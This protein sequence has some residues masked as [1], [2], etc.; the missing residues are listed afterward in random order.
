MPLARHSWLE[1]STGTRVVDRAGRQ[2][3]RSRGAEGAGHIPDLVDDDIG[4]DTIA[5]DTV[6]GEVVRN[7][8]EGFHLD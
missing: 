3:R 8:V 6:E 7:M 1:R 5:L 2:R 4:L